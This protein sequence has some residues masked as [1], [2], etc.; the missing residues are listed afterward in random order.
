M[1]VCV[2][3]VLEGVWLCDRTPCILWRFQSKSTAHPRPTLPLDED[4]F[5]FSLER[6]AASI[7]RRTSLSNTIAA[8]QLRAVR[9]AKKTGLRSVCAAVWDENR[10]PDF[11]F[12]P[13]L[14]SSDGTFVVDDPPSLS[15][16]REIDPHHRF[17]P[18]Y[19]DPQWAAPRRKNKSFVRS[20]KRR[21]S[22][23]LPPAVHQIHAGWAAFSEHL[24]FL[25]KRK[26]SF[27]FSLTSVSF[28]LARIPFVCSRY[29]FFFSLPN[30]AVVLEILNFDCRQ[31][32]FNLLSKNLRV[33]WASLSVG[34][35]I[36]D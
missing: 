18:P 23:F 1:C 32:S 2:C 5:F 12:I 26:I 31:F 24:L 36:N 35:L 3:V 7:N 8:A 14:N 27:L 25:K 19:T 4:V 13:K 11:S 10:F 16:A 17:R 9:N 29:F 33:P 30:L 34:S 22:Y 28:R 6:D 21:F 15:L 20:P